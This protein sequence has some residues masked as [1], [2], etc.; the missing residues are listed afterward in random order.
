MGGVWQLK[1]LKRAF[2]SGAF[3]AQAVSFFMFPKNLILHSWLQ[4]TEYV[5]IHEGSK[6]ISVNIFVG[7]NN[8]QKVYSYTVSLL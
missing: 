7:E 5:S 8:M 1:H 6:W 3:Q 2:S 4:Q